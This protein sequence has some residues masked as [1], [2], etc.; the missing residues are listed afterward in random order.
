MTNINGESYRRMIP[1][2]F[3]PNLRAHPSCPSHT[4]FQQAGET[5]HTARASMNLRFEY[6]SQKLIS[7]FGAIP[8]LPISPDLTLMDFFFLWGY[9]KK[10]V[11]NDNHLPRVALKENIHREISSIKPSLLHRVTLSTRLRFEQCVQLDG[12]HLDDVLFKK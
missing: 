4:W 1:E 11:N 3:L 9:L 10:K 6:F 12:R 8:W 5:A 7:R 2:F